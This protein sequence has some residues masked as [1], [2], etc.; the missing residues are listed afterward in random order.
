MT[1]PWLCALVLAVMATS[2][3]AQDGRYANADD[4]THY[5]W[6]DV[7][8]A[9]PVQGVTRTEVP[10]QECYEQPV[11]RREGGNSTAGTVLGAVIGGVLG[12]TV[13]KGDG[14]KA[15]TVAGAV[16]GGAIGN[17]ASSRGSE[18]ESTQTQ[19]REVSSISEQRR[20]IG[21]DVEYRYRGEIY[22][23]RLNYDPGERLRVR[24]RVDPAD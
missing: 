6:A 1:K 20:I 9:D 22:T 23:S 12:N 16:A 11:V 2:V 18:Y 24:V 3:H 17:R 4:N 21:Y 8:R 5:G 13:G 10:R 15:A 7:L 14:R 19:C